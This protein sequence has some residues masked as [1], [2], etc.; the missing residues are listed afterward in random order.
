MLE[1]THDQ[2]TIDRVDFDFLVNG[3]LLRGKIKSH[4]VRYEISCEQVVE[5]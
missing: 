5:I 3:K 1:S 4:L 2:Q